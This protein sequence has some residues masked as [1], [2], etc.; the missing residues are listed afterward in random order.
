MK[1]K[2]A[3]TFQAQNAKEKEN[4]FK[5]LSYEIKKTCNHI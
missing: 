3:S 2:T 5:K 1:S 4:N